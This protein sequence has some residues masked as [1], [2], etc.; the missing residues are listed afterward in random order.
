MKSTVSGTPVTSEEDLI[1]IVEGATE[2]LTRQPHLLCHV[3]E[4]QHRRCRLCNDVA[5]TQFEP[6]LYCRMLDVLHMFVLLT[7][8]GMDTSVLYSAQTVRFQKEVPS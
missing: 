1:A 5:S 3:C 7:T 4:S 2:S 8:C 6:R